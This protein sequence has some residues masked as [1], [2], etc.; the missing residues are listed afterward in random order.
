M[1][2]IRYVVKKVT[3]TKHQNEIE[4]Y[5]ILSIHDHMPSLHPPGTIVSKEEQD[6]E[7]LWFVLRDYQALNNDQAIVSAILNEEV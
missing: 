7:G 2:N 6:A 1:S 5:D 3:L 4:F